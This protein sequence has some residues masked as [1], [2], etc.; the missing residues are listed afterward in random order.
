[1]PG[2]PPVS[3]TGTTVDVMPVSESIPLT[4]TPDGNGVYAYTMAYTLPDGPAATWLVALQASRSVTPSST[5]AAPFYDGVA[6]RFIWPYTGERE[7]EVA[8]QVVAWVGVNGAT[9]VPRRTIVETARCSSC[10]LRLTGHG[11]RTAVVTCPACHAPNR[12]DWRA[13]N[14]DPVTRKVIVTYLASYDGIEERST[15]FKTFIHRLHTGTGA[16]TANLSAI[17]PFVIYGPRFY[18]EARFP[19]D[20]GRCTNC[21]AGKSY[22]VESVPADASPTVANETASVLHAGTQVHTTCEATPPVS[23]ACLSCHATAYARSHAAR[24]VTADGREACAPCHAAA[25]AYPVEKVHG[26]TAD[27]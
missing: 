3:D 27:P 14:R 26:F 7:S 1:V 9:P 24:Y 4:L 21:H 15:H 13:R 5:V 17:A 6:N 25:T 10:H 11:S 19:R 12:T 20:L 8:D 16:G 2:T 22:R 23:A 18:D